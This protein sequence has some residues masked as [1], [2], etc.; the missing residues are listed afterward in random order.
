MGHPAAQPSTI[1][2]LQVYHLRRSSISF[3][4]V[5]KDMQLYS[6]QN[7]ALKEVAEKAFKLERDLQKLIEANLELLMGL[8]VVKSEFVVSDCRFDTLAFDKQ[9]KAFTIIEYKRDKSFSV[10]DQGFRY[11]ALMLDR[12][13]DLLVGYNE[14]KKGS[15]KLKEVDWSQSRVVFVAP[16]FTDDQKQSVNFRD[17]PIDLWEI[18]QYANDVVTIERI[19]N[20]K[21]AGS[22]KTL[23]AKSAEMKKVVDEV[24][25]PTEEDHTVY[26]GETMAELYLKFKAAILN[27]ASGIEVKPLKLYIAFKKN[28]NIVDIELRKQELKLYLNAPYGSINDAKKLAKNVANVGHWGNGDYEIRVNDDSELEYIMSLVKQVL[29]RQ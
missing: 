16:E 13:A 10:I 23:A 19:G 8:S 21:S 12:R 7:G 6:N 24:K 11:L 1:G 20:S 29:A 27:L 22:F 14:Q 17:L 5:R 15:M 3:S 9:S 4:G 18:K 25:V 2:H 26:A 28:R